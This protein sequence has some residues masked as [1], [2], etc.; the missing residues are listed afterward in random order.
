ML[1]DKDVDMV[2][3]LVTSIRAVGENPFTMV[4]WASIIMV[5]TG[6]GLLTLMLGFVVVIPVIGHGTWH[7][8]KDLVDASG[9]PART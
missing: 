2:T 1:L 8:Y 4:V 9:L 3:A 5:A 6:I 7:A